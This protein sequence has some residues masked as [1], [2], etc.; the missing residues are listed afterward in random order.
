MSALR[1]L[2]KR[3][4]DAAPPMLTDDLATTIEAVL[5]IESGGDEH[6]V[7]IFDGMYTVQHPLG[8]RF[9]GDLFECR[10]ADAVG[11]FMAGEDD[12]RYRVRQNGDVLEWE[13]IE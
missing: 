3:T 6:V 4:L 2:I 12:G 13:V 9:E 11:M 8:E 7:R 10:I 1:D 5:L